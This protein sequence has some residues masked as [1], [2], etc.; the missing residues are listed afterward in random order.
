MRL[1]L[2][3]IET[4]NVDGSKTEHF[5]S[6]KKYLEKDNSSILQRVGPPTLYALNTY[7]SINR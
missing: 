1:K 7:I 6:I 5:E 4:H 2:L 3:S